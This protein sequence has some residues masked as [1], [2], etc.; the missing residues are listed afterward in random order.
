MTLS[1]RLLSFVG[2]GL[3]SIPFVTLCGCLSNA[4]AQEVEAQ[5]RPPAQGRQ[6]ADPLAVFPKDRISQA[7]DR[8]ATVRLS[9]HVHR[10]ARPEFYAGPVAGE[11]KMPGMILVLKRAA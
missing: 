4:V 7:I 3:F 2:A 1:R 5:Q 10:Q 11:T 6:I 9:G 8:R